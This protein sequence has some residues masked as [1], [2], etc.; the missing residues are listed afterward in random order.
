MWPAAGTA[1]A[2]E[3]RDGAADDE[4]R[5]GAALLQGEADH[6]GGGGFAVRA[7]DGD[8]RSAP[9]ITMPSSSAY[10]TAAGPGL[11]GQVFAIGVRDGG[12]A[13]D[14]IDLV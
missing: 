7:G 5:I 12:R 10:L 2:A 6:R 8:R 11:G 3:L 14:Q 4:T 9:A 13:N 1:A